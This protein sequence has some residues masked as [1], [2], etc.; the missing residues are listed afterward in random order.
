MW[1]MIP[2]GIILHKVIPIGTK[3]GVICVNPNW[4]YVKPSWGY[5]YK[6][7]IMQGQFMSSIEV[8]G[9]K[10]NNAHIESLEAWWLVEK[11]FPRVDP[12]CCPTNRHAEHSGKVTYAW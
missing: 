8:C 11:T 9:H 5:W 2:V 12:V 6:N 7:M 10:N 3:K 4:D 1:K